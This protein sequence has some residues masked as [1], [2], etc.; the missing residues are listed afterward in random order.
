MI[1]D[2]SRLRELMVSPFINFLKVDISGYTFFMNNQ[3]SLQSKTNTLNQ[4]VHGIWSHPK[5]GVE[6]HIH[7][8]PC[9]S[10]LE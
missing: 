9:I 8:H 4:G 1:E 3:Y 2:M 6:A 7:V 5:T 10:I